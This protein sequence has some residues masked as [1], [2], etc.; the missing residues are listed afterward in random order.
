MCSNQCPS[1]VR[2]L[3]LQH[4]VTYHF[5]FDAHDRNAARQFVSINCQR[6]HRRERARAFIHH[7]QYARTRIHKNTSAAAADRPI[8]KCQSGSASSSN[9]P[10]RM[11]KYHRR[12]RTP[13]HMRP[14]IRRA[15]LTAARH[16]AALG[17]RYYGWVPLNSTRR[18]E[19]T[20]QCTRWHMH[21]P[22]QLLTRC[23]RALRSLP[24]KRSIA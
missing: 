1:L 8:G 2:L 5:V 23:A 22:L 6:I 16:I 21:A 12:S 24:L 7:G 13:Q 14:A 3:L 10:H 20:L 15:A 4:R 19:S 9:R 17:W 18:S 11:R